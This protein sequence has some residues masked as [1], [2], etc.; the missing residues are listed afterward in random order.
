MTLSNFR[1][2]FR[3]VFQEKVSRI[4]WVM[5]YN[6]SSQINFAVIDPSGRISC[7]IPV[8]ECKVRRWSPRR[9]GVNSKGVR[10]NLAQML[11][12]RERG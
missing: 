5:P 11:C 10:G 1:E 12:A 3:D 9:E 4:S 2:T 6:P 7:I 8:M